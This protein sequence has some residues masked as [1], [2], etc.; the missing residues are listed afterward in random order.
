M[1]GKYNGHV[2]KIDMTPDE[3]H[4]HTATRLARKPICGVYKI[5]VEILSR[6]TAAAVALRELVVCHRGH[7]HAH[8]SLAHSSQYGLSA[9]AYR[10]NGGIEKTTQQKRI[11]RSI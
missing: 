5:L 4:N 8:I 2:E 6:E 10:E 9:F 11:K 3:R 1:C 7:T